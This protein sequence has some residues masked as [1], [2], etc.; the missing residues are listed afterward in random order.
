MEDVSAKCTRCEKDLDTTGYPR[1]CRACKGKYQREYNATRKEMH[2][3]RGF[4]AGASAFRAAVVA[5]MRLFG[6]A[7]FSGAEVASMVERF[8]LEMPDTD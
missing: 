7:H 3:T 5:R 2:E 1:W 6:S 4:A 8:Q